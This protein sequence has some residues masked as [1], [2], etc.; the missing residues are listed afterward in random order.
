MSREIEMKH[1]GT[2]A[3]ARA[4]G[5]MRRMWFGDQVKVWTSL[6]RPATG[7][8]NWGGEKLGAKAGFVSH[9]VVGLLLKFCAFVLPSPLLDNGHL[10]AVAV[11]EASLSLVTGT[12]VDDLCRGWGET[13]MLDSSLSINEPRSV[14]L[15][16]S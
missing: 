14:W 6:C 4:A 8:V 12:A 16:V 9:L 10:Q 1:E 5:G 13:V 3:N 11:T 7:K 2:A 15:F